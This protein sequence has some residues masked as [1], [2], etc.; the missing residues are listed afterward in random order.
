MPQSPRSPPLPQAGLPLPPPTVWPQLPASPTPAGP[1]P[2]GAAA[3]GPGAM[4]PARGASPCG[5]R[6]VRPI[7]TVPR[8]S[9]SAR[10]A[11]SKSVPT[12][13]ANGAHRPERTGLAPGALGPSSSSLT[14]EAVVAQDAKSAQAWGSSW[15]PC[16][17]GVSGVSA[18]WQP[19]SG[20]GPGAIVCT[21]DCPSHALL[22][23]SSRGAPRPRP[24]A[25]RDVPGQGHG[26]KSPWRSGAACGWRRLLA[27]SAGPYCFRTTTAWRPSG[28]GQ[29]PPPGALPNG[30]RRCCVAG[31]GAGA[32]GASSRVSLAAPPGAGPGRGAGAAGATGAPRPA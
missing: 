16:G 12:M 23:L 24:A 20:R 10:P 32:A 29:P 2:H 11:L 13:P 5:R 3:H 1:R 19:A 4:R 22:A 26:G 31:G 17:R 15:P 27:P 9:R 21:R 8:T 7:G 14:P 28:L 18:R 6:A 25:K 30:D